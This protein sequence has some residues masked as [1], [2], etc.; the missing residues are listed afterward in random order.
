M[1]FLKNKA[2]VV[3]GGSR[4]I[5]RSIVLMLA[6]N[7]C[8]VAFNYHTSAEE[9]KK[10]E[11][12]AKKF[13]VDCKASRVDIK[14]FESVK[15]WIEEVKKDFGRLDILINNAGIIS[16]KALM[17]MSPE[18]W[19]TVVDTNLTGVFNAARCCI[20]TFLKQKKG[21]IINISSVSGLIGLPRQVN[22]SATKGGINAFTKALAKEV[23]A[24]GVRVNAVA[25]GYI[26]TEIL[27]NFSP[28]QKEKI[29]EDIP[30]GRLGTVEDVANCVKFLLS[31]DAQYI[32]GQIIPLDGGLAMR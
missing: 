31:E 11:Q 30:L 12:E 2:A 13:G 7:G 21:D 25:P 26:E 10:V 17:L 19:Q 9:A 27:A 28:E 16:D 3:T 5:G 1:S 32:T 4:G 18:D 23:A 29:L 8:H 14:D 24:Y 22:Y 6:Q 15:T 20:V